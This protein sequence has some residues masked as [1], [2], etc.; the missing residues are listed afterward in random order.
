MKI[1][2]THDEEKQA[3]LIAMDHHESECL[4]GVMTEAICWRRRGDTMF[5]SMYNDIS[6]A[7]Q[8]AGSEASTEDRTAAKLDALIQRFKAAGIQPRNWRDMEKWALEIR[9]AQ[10]AENSE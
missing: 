4:Y 2:V 5:R 10:E 9:A 1:N 6:I 3:Y 8:G 7:L